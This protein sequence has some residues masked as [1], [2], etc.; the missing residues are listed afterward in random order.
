MPFP[1]Q[2]KHEF[3]EAGVSAILPKQS[4]VYAIF[5]DSDCL[6]MEQSV[7]IRESLLLHVCRQSVESA[8]IYN[9]NPTYWLALVDAK[10]RL[11]YLKGLLRVEQM[12]LCT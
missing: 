3:T 5:N 11:R 1:K 2:D 8:C 12:P 6:Y 10:S 9:Y 7:D 4:G